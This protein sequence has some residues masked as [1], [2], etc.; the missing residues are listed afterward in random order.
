MYFGKLTRT[1]PPIPLYYQIKTRFI[2]ALK[3]GELKPGDPISPEEKLCADFG[4]SRGTARLAIGELVKEG[5]L[6]RE[7]GRGTFVARPRLERSLNGYFR[8]AERDS[9]EAVVPE[10]RVIKTRRLIPPTDVAKTLGITAK[11]RVIEIRRLRLVKENPFIYQVSFFPEKLFPRLHQL[12]P[13]IQ[14]LYQHISERYGLHIVQVEEY[15]T[16]GLP[17]EEAQSFLRLEANAPV[18]VIERI[19]FTFNEKPVEFR[20][21]VGRADRYHYRIRL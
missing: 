4:V 5:L 8:F 10:S 14:S 12:E 21:S 13:N 6:W 18:I 17:N 15:L 19:A 1:E 9:S 3:S 16:A 11:E 7:R 20:V 2:D